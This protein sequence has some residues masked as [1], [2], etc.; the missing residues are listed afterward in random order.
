MVQALEVMHSLATGYRRLKGR[1]GSVGYPLVGA[2]YGEIDTEGRFQDMVH[3]RG[4]LRCIGKIQCLEISRNPLQLEESVPE[5][6]ALRVPGR[7]F[8]SYNA[9]DEG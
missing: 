7:I 9:P 3:K 4:K 5:P 2:G 1:Q 6:G 8:P